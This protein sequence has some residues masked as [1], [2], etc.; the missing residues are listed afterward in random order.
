MGR[1]N[2]E[3]QVSVAVKEKDD[4]IAYL[5]SQIQ[6]HAARASHINT[7]L[8]STL[9]TLDVLQAAHD[10][11]LASEVRAKERLGVKLDRYIDFTRAS[12][13]EKEDMKE[14]VLLLV[15]KVEISK[16]YSL[17]PHSR[18]QC[19]QLAEPLDPPFINPTQPVSHEQTQA[20][21]A[22]LIYALRE[23]RDFERRDHRQFRQQAE[24][25]IINLEARLARRD[26]ELEAWLLYGEKPTKPPSDSPKSSPPAERERVIPQRMSTEDA[27]QA[28]QTA[29]SR[30]KQLELEVRALSG[31]LGKARIR[32]ASLVNAPSAHPATATLNPTGRSSASPSLPFKPNTSSPPS[33]PSQGYSS[34]GQHHR[35]P[36]CTLPDPPLADDNDNDSSNDNDITIRPARNVPSPNNSNVVPR[37]IKSLEHQIS[38]L[39]T[40]VDAFQTERKRLGKVVGGGA[41]ALH[42]HD[43]REGP[44]G[45]QE[46]FERVLRIEEECIRLAKAES[47]AQAALN[48][49]KTAAV[50]RERE[51]QDEIDRLRD[52][53]Q[54]QR[55]PPPPDDLD[56]LGDAED[57]E[58]MELA[59][60]LL[61]SMPLPP[62]RDDYDYVDPPS[63]PLP[64]SRS[65]SP[66]PSSS[67]SPSSQGTRLIHLHALS[68]SSADPWGRAQAQSSPGPG[69]R[70]D[71]KHIQDLESRLAAA[72][73]DLEDRERALHEVREEL[74]R[75][76]VRAP[77]GGDDA[78]DLS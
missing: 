25:H 47:A 62:G 56:L 46:H 73:Q 4:H 17:W 74:E 19:T 45:D 23:E 26:A 72:R 75:L 42:D 48:T 38:A 51:L 1:K 24:S 76:H 77:P 43:A 57:E 31:M 15:E 64:L 39:G 78:S 59:T 71:H 33:H 14:A 67:P 7:R 9:D 40:Q 32:A 5:E 68:G 58:S 61:V 35:R 34:L 65:P 10:K 70:D 12:E 49:L 20:Y 53:I 28:M 11:E 54:I 8:L 60:P 36:S 50:L 16:D 18:M 30:N 41:L 27:L 6:A 29:S 52:A 2:Y 55:S 63:I 3:Q 22:A 13:V 69:Q 66:T 44:D 21:A 37:P